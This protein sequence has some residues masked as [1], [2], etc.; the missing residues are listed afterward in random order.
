M[1]MVGANHW[2]DHCNGFC[3]MTI[4]LLLAQHIYL[5]TLMFRQQAQQHLVFMIQASMIE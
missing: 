2:S 3:R 4:A 5:N 1:S